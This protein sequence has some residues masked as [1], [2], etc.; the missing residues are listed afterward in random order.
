MTGECFIVETQQGRQLAGP[1][2]EG[3]ARIWIAF[4]L[5]RY[6]APLRIVCVGSGWAPLLTYRTLSEVPRGVW[7]VQ[8]RAEVIVVVTAD[9]KAAVYP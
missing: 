8:R 9:G 3:A 6:R 5:H 7:A 2:D 1:F 4:N